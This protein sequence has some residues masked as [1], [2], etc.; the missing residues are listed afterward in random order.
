MIYNGNTNININININIKKTQ[1]M[2]SIS[3]YLPGKVW[4][5]MS[6][7]QHFE[8]SEKVI[9]QNGQ[10]IHIYIYVDISM[11]P[12]AHGGREERTSD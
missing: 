11:W 4:I 9:F 10:K 7:T 6:K 12:W 5:E 8:I 2:V 1:N 3:W